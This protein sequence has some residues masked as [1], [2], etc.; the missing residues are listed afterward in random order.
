MIAQFTALSPRV[1]V[2]QMWDWHSGDFPRSTMTQQS[3]STMGLLTLWVR[4]LF[5][6]RGGFGVG[7]LSR[8][9]KDVNS[10]P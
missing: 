9:L 2:W 7:G 5:P 3:F 10:I 4:E 1:A 8:A 6:G